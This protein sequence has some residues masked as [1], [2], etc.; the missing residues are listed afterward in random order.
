MQIAALQMCSS[1]DWKENLSAIEEACQKAQQLGVR[2]LQLPEMAVMFAEHPDQLKAFVK[3]DDHNQALERLGQLA[4]DHQLYLHVGSMAVAAPN[5]KC[6]NRAF[7]F[8]PT[9]DI[10]ASYDKIHLFDADVQG[11][12]PY[13]ESDNFAPGEKAVLAPIDDFQLGFAICYDVRFPKLFG[14]L[15]QAGADLLSVPAA[16]TVP[17]GQAHWQSLLRARAI[18]TGCYLVAAAQSGIH[19]NGRKTYGH[20]KIINPWG[21]IV[22]SCEDGDG[23]LITAS[24]DAQ[25]IKDA[26]FR[27]PTLANAREFSLSVNHNAAQ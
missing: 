4:R 9:G 2:Y 3:S 20:S 14:A 6:F 17:T 11:D 19:Q 8:A 5:N 18:E 16:F 27:I 12:K 25:A 13:R 22:A 1:M 23:L 26:R 10:V 15:R 7:L 21:E 24:L